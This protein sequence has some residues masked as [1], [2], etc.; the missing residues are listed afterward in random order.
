MQV[1]TEP[2]SSRGGD[3]G[4]SRWFW[5][6]AGIFFWGFLWWIGA[7]VLG[8]HVTRSALT[9]VTFYLVT[10][11]V[12]T[13]AFQDLINGFPSDWPPLVWFFFPIMALLATAIF[14]SFL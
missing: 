10:T 3:F 8:I 5:F 6:G 2:P 4:H 1:N 9:D 13:F 14:A 7:T 11:L 12:L